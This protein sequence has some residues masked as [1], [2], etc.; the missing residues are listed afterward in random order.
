MTSAYLSSL[1]NRMVPRIIYLFISIIVN[2]LPILLY[3]LI[4]AISIDPGF[5]IGVALIA[6][7]LYLYFLMQIAYYACALPARYLAMSVIPAAAV[8][9]MTVP[10]LSLAGAI[11]LFFL[12]LPP[13]HM[14][15]KFGVFKGWLT[16]V[17]WLIVWSILTGLIGLLPNVLLGPQSRIWLWTSEPPIEPA[18]ALVVAASGAVATYLLGRWW[19]SLNACRYK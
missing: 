15:V 9:L 3:K 8:Y 18:R 12:F 10:G 2:I 19:R 14:G 17:A 11:A 1:V 6:V 4:V 13:L 16:A 7:G 5:R